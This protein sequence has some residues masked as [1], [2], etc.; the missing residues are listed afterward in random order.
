MKRERGFTLIEGL[1][2]LLLVMLILGGLAKTL[3]N[4]GKVR[5]NR[6]NMDRAVD[7]LHALQTLRA[8]MLNGLSVTQPAPGQTASTVAITMVDPDLSFGQ[9]TDPLQ[10]PELPFET[11][12]Q[13]EVVY[14]VEEGTLRRVSTAPGGPSRNLSLLATSALQASRVG[15]LVTL[16]LD[17]SYSRVTKSRILKVDLR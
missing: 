11:S 8:D 2:S 1:F 10:G 9:R 4:A 3:V 12:E 7:E 16:T 6:E 13:I 17:F 5:S 14:R 15:S